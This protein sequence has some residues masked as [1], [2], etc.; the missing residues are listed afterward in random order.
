MSTVSLTKNPPDSWT[1]LYCNSL[2]ANTLNAYDFYVVAQLFQQ[3]Y[4]GI[5]AA[6]TS[7]FTSAYT[8][9]LANP[10]LSITGAGSG[11]IYMALPQ[12]INT[13]NGYGYAPVSVTPVYILTGA[14]TSVAGFLGRSIV[15][16]GQ[17]INSTSVPVTGTLTFGAS[18]NPQGGTLTVTNSN[19]NAQN[20]FL[21]LE[22]DVTLPAD[23]TMYFYGC[24]LNYFFQP[25]GNLQPQ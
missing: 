2:T 13:R 4:S 9:Y 24:Y 18:S 5:T 20:Q 17:A 21:F 25:Y 23:V 12:G 16:P 10:C 1:N 11:S 14:A 8:T 7:A 3:F 6:A 22:L 19:F 15:Y